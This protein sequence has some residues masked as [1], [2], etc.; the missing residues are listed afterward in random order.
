[1]LG[2][3]FGAMEIMILVMTTGMVVGMV[4]SMAA[5]M[6]ETGLARGAEMG[7]LGG[8]AV[9]IAK[10]LGIDIS[11]RI[12]RQGSVPCRSPPGQDRSPPDGCSRYVVR[13]E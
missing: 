4:V 7:A 5:S 10:S 13:G 11:D 1:M 12:A 3:F 8:V 9:M 6:G 2:A